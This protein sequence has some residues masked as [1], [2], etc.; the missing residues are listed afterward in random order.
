[1]THIFQLSLQPAVNW[2]I[3]KHAPP[4]N[5]FEDLDALVQDWRMSRPDQLFTEIRSLFDTSEKN[6]NK[7]SD[8]GRI[9]IVKNELGGQ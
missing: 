6:K 9:R 2:I 5:L 3:F 7:N 4:V 8:S 1:M